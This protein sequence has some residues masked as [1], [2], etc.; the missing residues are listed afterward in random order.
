MR[1]EAITNRI[2]D[3]QGNHCRREGDIFISLPDVA[4]SRVA[5][6]KDFELFMKKG[7]KE[8][9]LSPSSRPPSSPPS[10][11]PSPPPDLQEK[12]STVLKDVPMRIMA[13]A[14][15]LG[16][17]QTKNVLITYEQLLEFLGKCKET[18]SLHQSSDG[19]LVML[20]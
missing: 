18:F 8:K 6:E 15:L 20:K 17:L 11:P 7:F 14:M 1:I 13:V 3:A 12:I 5:T 19:L 10:P 2:L 9:F 16:S 4:G